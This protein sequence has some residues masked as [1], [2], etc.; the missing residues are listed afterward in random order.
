MIWNWLTYICPECQKR[1]KN[2]LNHECDIP[3]H[4]FYCNPCCSGHVCAL[5]FNK[6]TSKS[7]EAE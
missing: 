5:V 3:G 2:K 1:E 6:K 7:K 4:Y